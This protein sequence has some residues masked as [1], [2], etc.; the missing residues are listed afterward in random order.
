MKENTF[1]MIHNIIYLSCSYFYGPE[2]FKL[3]A[4]NLLHIVFRTSL[5][6]VPSLCSSGPNLGSH[7][8]LPRYWYI[9]AVVLGLLIMALAVCITHWKTKSNKESTHEKPLQT[10]LKLVPAGKAHPYTL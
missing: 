5:N 8:F 9:L 10:T 4:F 7:W 6:L 3:K 2:V 1:V